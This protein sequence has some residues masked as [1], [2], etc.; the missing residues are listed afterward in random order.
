MIRL[1]FHTPQFEPGIQVL[2][3]LPVFRLE[4]TG[5]LPECSPSLIYFPGMCI[6]LLLTLLL[7]RLALL[8]QFLTVV[9]RRSA[10]WRKERERQ[11]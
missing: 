8:A 7:C 11:E 6:F 2:S 5:V 3:L 9:R 10:R 4:I 1:E